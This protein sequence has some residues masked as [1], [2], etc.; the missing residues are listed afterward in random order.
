MYTVS[1]DKQKWQLAGYERAQN[2]DLIK[3]I[4]F[5]L[6]EAVCRQSIPILFTL[7]FRDA[8]DFARCQ[9]VIDANGYRLISLELTAPHE[10]LLQR[11]RARVESAKRGESK[12]SI[13]DEAL[14]VSNLSKRY[15]IPVGSPLFDTSLMSAEDIASNV[16]RMIHAVE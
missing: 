15:F 14:F 11:F 8:P 7:G 6:F 16:V 13:T 3:E 2:K 9:S 10:V 12:I 1:Y 5:G 4:T